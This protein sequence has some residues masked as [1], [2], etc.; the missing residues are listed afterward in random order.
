VKFRLLLFLAAIVPLFIFSGANAADYVTDPP[1]RQ[2]KIVVPYVE[3]EW[4]LIHWSDNTPACRIIVD[5]EGLP[6]DD[7]VYIYCGTDRFQQWLET[8]ACNP[9]L[10]GA[11]TSDCKGL[12]LLQIASE[13]KEKIVLVDLPIPEA[14]IVVEGCTPI[15]PE[16]RCEDL[17]NLVITAEEPLPN[18]HI[19]Q[20][21]GTYNEIPFVCEGET[22]EVPLR[23]TVDEG[24]VVTFWADSSFGDSGMH[25]TAIVRVTDG[26]VSVA[27]GSGGWYVDIMSDRWLDAQT[28]GC[29]PI[30]RSFPP[31]GG[32]PD[33]LA[34]PEWP[35]LLSTEAPYSYLAGRLISQGIVDADACPA[36]GLEVNGYANTCGL[37]SARPEVDSWQNRF[38][39]KIVTVA[40]ETGIPAQLMKNLFAQESQFWPGVFNGAEEYGFGQLTPLGAD[41]VLLWN[42]TFY[43][44]FCPFVL[45]LDSCNLGYAHLEEEDQATLRGALAVRANADCETCESGIDL[46]YADYSIHIFAQTILANCQQVAQII[47]NARGVPPSE[48][49][50]YEDLWHFTLGNYHAGPGCLSNAIYATAGQELTWE[51]VAPKLDLECPGAVDYVTN[52]AK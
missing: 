13:P 37:E 17:P 11:D 43:N 25:Y 16:N 15:L 8:K 23:P 14:W 29:S 38:D 52:I 12:Y 36:G 9:V 4:W 3:F 27:P 39:E 33:W 22:C 5:H 19:T 21:Q 42:P 34:T 18:E 47:T 45:D 35:E 7:D 46:S 51:N 48:V 31:V 44:Q 20:I 49:S 28:L 24:V 2:T 40:Q 32:P 1:S 41:T 10:E 6:Y 50:T 26:G 30:W